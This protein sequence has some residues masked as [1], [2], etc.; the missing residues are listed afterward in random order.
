VGEV[1]GAGEVG[2][3]GEVGDAEGDGVGDGAGD[4]G[5]AAGLAVAIG[6]G[7]GV[8]GEGSAGV[9]DV[10]LPEQATRV[11]PMRRDAALRFAFIRRHRWCCGL[12]CP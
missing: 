3:V 5:A 1:D 12:S 2:G 11:T 6:V 4:P 7:P 9:G 8:D 10:A